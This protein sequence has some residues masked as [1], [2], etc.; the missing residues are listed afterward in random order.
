M[1]ELHFLHP[2]MLMAA[3]AAVLPAI[4][5]LLVRHRPVDLDFPTVRFIKTSIKTSAFKFRVRN[6]LLLLARCALIVLF[7][8][9]LARPVIKGEHFSAA[10]KAV[11]HAV[12]VLD[13]SYSMRYKDEGRERFQAAKAMALELMR[14]FEVGSQ[15]ALLTTSNPVGSL[16]YD[17]DGVR[18]QIEDAK[19]GPRMTSVWPALARARAMLAERREAGREVYVLTDLT[20]Q[21]FAAAGQIGAQF[22]GDIGLC[23]VDCG[24]STSDN[25]AL[26]DVTL[27]RREAPVGCPV[28]VTVGG[29]ATGPGGERVVQLHVDGQKVGQK[30]VCFPAEG[31]AECE[32]EF[33]LSR[34]GTCRG[35]A[36]LV[37]DDLLE[38]DNYRHFTAV[39][40][41][42]RRVLCVNGSPADGP[43]DEL[44][45]LVRALK[46]EA[47]A[48]G[49]S[50][51]VTVCSPADL[52]GPRPEDWD[53]AVLCNVPGLSADAWRWL[54]DRVARG[55]GLIV[56][57]GDNLT[58][59]AYNSGAAGALMPARVA[60]TNAADQPL[61][62]SLGEP[63]HPLAEPFVDGR[64]GDLTAASF[65]RYLGLECTA[66]H[67][68]SSVPI[69]LGP[70]AP[71]VVT[72]PFQS[73]RVAAVAVPADADWGDFPKRP[74]FA[75][76]VHELIDYVA[77]HRLT[78]GDITVG[79]PATLAL[80][81]DQ[82]NSSVRIESPAG[83]GP[84]PVTVQPK[85]L[86]AEFRD[87]W[88]P[89]HYQWRVGGPE[90][91]G[92]LGF[93]VNLQSQESRLTRV[94]SGEVSK[95]FPHARPLVVRDASE[96]TLAVRQTRVGQE[97]YPWLVLALLALMVG[98]S[99]LANRFYGRRAQS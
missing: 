88:Q 40:I 63:S 24:R 80:R 76:F 58:P 41:E 68:A 35:T 34:P 92:V 50:V 4:I 18:K 39:G 6:L 13:D 20:G 59:D 55:K 26:T 75:P 8:A 45:Y 42:S 10:D 2:A 81:P 77:S 32:F 74:C 17:L 48:R 91:E 25:F 93:A 47:L 19:P 96:L 90:G 43:R 37:G 65:G 54:A 79:V 64:N 12:V 67:A 33:R 44:F 1:L 85:R 94:A 70:Q 86:A 11:V 30:S 51:E 38:V 56:F 57:A 99:Y 16:T 46:P 69:T 95:A 87:T 78:T 52:A 97:T 53:V 3:T 29:L 73:G 9:I 15:V 62:F 89:G 31:V 5:H 14:G 83:R 61:S 71:G 28:Q 22:K 7:A 98:E 49:P 72:K 23:I 82:L 84:R 27:S 60:A 66:K 21:A 36:A